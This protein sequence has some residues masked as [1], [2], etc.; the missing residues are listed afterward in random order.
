MLH[1][2]LVLRQGRMGKYTDADRKDMSKGENSKRGDEK[3]LSLDIIFYGV[4]W[5]NKK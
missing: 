1:S 4:F 5:G 3:N 2:S